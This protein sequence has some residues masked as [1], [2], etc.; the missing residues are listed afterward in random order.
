MD[1]HVHALI[2]IGVDPLGKVM[3]RI[4]THYSRYRHKQLRT[5][6][7]LFERRYK[8]WLVDTDH[9][10]IELLRYIHLNPV[11]AKMVAV[12]DEYLWSSHK[13]YLGS[14]VLP[15]LTINF[16]LG[17][18]GQT[19][20]VSAPKLPRPMRRGAC[21]IKNRRFQSAAIGRSKGHWHGSISGFVATLAD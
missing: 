21:G 6:G 5:T 10:F 4:A 18:L 12:A 16:G 8:A 13:A 14:E 11:E 15:W 9:Y 19:L 3:Q 20:D 2:Q 1:H 7:H 17:L